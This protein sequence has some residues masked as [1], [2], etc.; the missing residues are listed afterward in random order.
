MLN[1]SEMFLS[2][3]GEVNGNGVLKPSFFIRLAGCNLDCPY[4]DTQYSKEPGTPMEVSEIVDA[5]D[6]AGN[7]GK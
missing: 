7:P 4:C 5:V 3:D 2:F 6:A 1:V